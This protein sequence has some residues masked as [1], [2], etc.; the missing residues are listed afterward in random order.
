[1]KITMAVKINA[2]GDR[3]VLGEE[4]REALAQEQDEGFSRSAR[5]I[6]RGD[7]HRGIA[8]ASGGL[9]LGHSAVWGV[10][11]YSRSYRLFA[12]FR[13]AD[14]RPFGRTD[15]PGRSRRIDFPMP[16]GYR[17]R[18]AGMFIAY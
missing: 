8:A 12:Q 18:G 7:P 4:A 5:I 11:A 2:H 3:V 6:G 15:K 13:P 10:G 14:S 17:C 1:M 16:C 9:S